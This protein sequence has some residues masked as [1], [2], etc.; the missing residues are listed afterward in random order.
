MEE[1]Y[2]SLS[3]VASLLGRFHS[4]LCSPRATLVVSRHPAGVSICCAGCQLRVDGVGDELH[5]SG[6]VHAAGLCD[7]V[8]DVQQSALQTPGGERQRKTETQGGA[9]MGARVNAVTPKKVK[10]T[11]YKKV[12]CSVCDK[13][14]CK[15]SNLRV[16][17]H[18]HLGV[19]PH[20]CRK[21]GKSFADPSTLSRH[22]ASVC[23]GRRHLTCHVC[24]KG[25]YH[26]T[27]LNEHVRK[28]T[29]EKP[30]AC[31]GCGKRYTCQGS[32]RRHQAA[33]PLCCVAS[34]PAP[35]TRGDAPGYGEPA[36][37]SARSPALQTAPSSA[38]E[39]GVQSDSVRL[40]P[41]VEM[42]QVKPEMFGVGS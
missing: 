33:G 10:V 11:S 22:A 2:L 34:D 15:R 27:H 23:G 40:L 30:Y 8:L 20:W 28:H 25:F 13:V 19:R 39:Y 4:A 32:L 38:A 24:G 26:R 29:G 36:P 18:S 16:H 12:Q 3:T 6:Y 35:G 37:R 42:G 9:D 5:Q 31:Q 1:I 21:C 14:F 7:A 17:M 41:A